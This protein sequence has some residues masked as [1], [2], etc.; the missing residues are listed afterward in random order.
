[1]E[2]QKKFLKAVSSEVRLPIE[3]IKEEDVLISKLEGPDFINACGVVKR[4]VV[5]SFKT[6]QS[7]RDG[8]SIKIRKALEDRLGAGKTVSMVCFERRMNKMFGCDFVLAKPNYK[9]LLTV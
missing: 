8:S 9:S 5:E 2:R 1:M 6:C 3:A 7:V 4:A